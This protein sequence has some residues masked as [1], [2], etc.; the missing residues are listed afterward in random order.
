MFFFLIIGMRFITWGSG[1]TP[2]AMR[3]GNCDTA[4]PFIT[5]SGMRFITLFFFVPVIPLSG[6][7]SLLQCPAC[8]TRYQAD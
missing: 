1:Q 5:K 4:A 7:K 8:G 3:C 6:V 2:H